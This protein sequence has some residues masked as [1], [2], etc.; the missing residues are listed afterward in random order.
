MHKTISRL[1]IIS[2][3]FLSDC[4][5]SLFTFD[6][7][8]K[9]WLFAFL[10][11]FPYLSSFS[12]KN[13]SYFYDTHPVKAKAFIAFEMPR[14]TTNFIWLWSNL[15]WFVV[16]WVAKILSVGVPN[17]TNTKANFQFSFT[18]RIFPCCLHMYLQRF[19]WVWVNIESGI[20]LPPVQLQQRAV[21]HEV[22]F[23]FFRKRIL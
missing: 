2:F 15:R 9:L 16:A 21:L 10:K 5:F 1:K 12:S 14:P 23:S 19:G 20:L 17:C 6:F 18:L 3:D 11:A 8:L 7:H 13:F 4:D 22:M